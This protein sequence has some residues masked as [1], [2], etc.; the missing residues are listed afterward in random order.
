VRYLSHLLR[1]RGQALPLPLPHHLAP[2][3]HIFGARFLKVARR[4]VSRIAK[5]AKMRTLVAP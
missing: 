2:R 4:M 5:K 3:A 1:F